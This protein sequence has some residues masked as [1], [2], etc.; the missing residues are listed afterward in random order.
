MRFV[1]RQ[2]QPYAA[3]ALLLALANACDPQDTCEDI[4]AQD[5]CDGATGGCAATDP[6]PIPAIRPA[7]TW[8][9]DPSDLDD[10]DTLRI[11][12][13]LLNTN[14]YALTRWYQD[15]GYADQ[16]GEYLKLGG[17][18]ELH[19]RSAASVAMALAVSLELDAYD[20]EATT[21]T[22]EIAE[23][24]AL[25]LIRSIAHRHR[26]NTPRGW[27][28]DWQTPLW[29]LYA[30]TGAWLMW[31]RLDAA[32]AEHVRRMVEDEARR[33]VGYQ[34]PYYRDERGELTHREED[35][36]AEENAWNAQFLFLA[37][38]MLPGHPMRP[39]WEFKAAELAAGAH[40]RPADLQDGSTILGGRPMKDWLHGSNVEPDGAVI[41]HGIFNPDYMVTAAYPASAPIWYGL[42]GGLTPDIMFCGASEIYRALVD[43]RWYGR[44]IYTPGSDDIYYPEGSS[45]GEERRIN[46]AYF[47]IVA[48]HFAVD[49]L[50]SVKAPVWEQLHAQSALDAQRR[51]ADGRTY[52][53]GDEDTYEGREEWVAAHAAMA[54]LAKWT[55]A[56]GTY[57]RRDGF[58]PVVID[59]QDLEF[60]ISGPW[61]D[62]RPE[63]RLGDRNLYHAGDC[64]DGER[65]AQWR[66]HAPLPAGTYR[67]SAWWSAYPNHASDAPYSVFHAGGETVVEVDQR[68]DGGRW[69]SLGEFEFDGADGHVELW[70]RTGSGYVVA[71]GVMFEKL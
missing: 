4:R 15:S 10:P 44:T 16:T 68:V 31:D 20:E 42:G 66:P 29:A 47:D 55:A 52:L 43:I 70:N 5:E 57:T 17:D 59:D 41:N 28:R 6:G 27:G 32:G 2:W 67:V 11:R 9:V 48:R 24:R 51:S 71:D 21:V 1:D 49:T 33:M 8:T 14:R 40:A 69:N 18:S 46:F 12:S 30:G 38:N 56:R 36:A 37:V 39:A 25:T 65:R 7:I 62:S 35:S 19:V 23:E 45:W 26:I 53:D 61:Q 63:D 13:I 58:V 34:V 50:V 54:Y 60:N 22:R 64:T 3:L